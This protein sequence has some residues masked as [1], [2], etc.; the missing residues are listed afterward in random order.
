MADLEKYKEDFF[1]FLEA[2]FIAV[3]QADE[4]S[5]LKLFRASQ[6]LNPKSY[7]SQIGIGYLHLHKL[8]VKQACDT[9]QE[10]LDKDPTNDMARAL[11]G[12]SKTFSPDKVAEGEKLLNDVATT[13]KDEDI[14]KTANT[15][16]DFVDNFIKTTPSPAEVNNKN[17]K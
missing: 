17:K 12:I 14:K 2:G 3:N 7:M 6:M 15:A 9:F 10:V 16:I 4:D 1:L 5:A 11:L 8:E 13:S